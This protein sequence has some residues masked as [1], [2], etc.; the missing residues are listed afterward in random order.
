[1]DPNMELRKLP[2]SVLF[3]LAKMLDAGDNW[4]RLMAIVPR[5]LDVGQPYVPKYKVE[6]IKLIEHAAAK[7]HRS[8]TEIFLDEWGTSGKRR[9]NLQILMEQLVA[10]HLFRAVDYVATSLLQVPPPERPTSGP[11]ARVDVS[12][13]VLENLLP[14]FMN[15]GQEVPG[16]F[17][18]PLGVGDDSSRGNDR[19]LTRL[20]ETLPEEHIAMSRVP[21]NPS[22]R[23]DTRLPHYQFCDLERFT[24]N[25]CER[26]I[27]ESHGR[28]L[29][30]GAFGTVYLGV[31]P[32]RE[33]VAV[34]RLNRD[35]V[36]VVRQ[37]R[38][39]VEALS[40]YQH[41]NLLPL[42]GYSSDGPSYCLVYQYMSNGSLQERL[43]SQA[44]TLL[45][46]AS[47]AW[48]ANT[49]VLSSTA[50]DGEIE[51]PNVILPWQLRLRIALGTARGI[52]HLHIAYEKP[53]IHRDIKSANIL[54]DQDLQPKLGDFGLV[55]LGSSGQQSQSVAMTTTVFGT[56]AYMAPEAFRGDV[57]V[58]LDTFSFGVVLLELLTGLPPYDEGREGC[59]LVT[60]VEEI[61][62][63][64]IVPLL[65]VRAGDWSRTIYTPEGKQP[66]GETPPVLAESVYVV[67][68]ECLEEKRRRPTMM[69]VVQ[70]VNTIVTN[71]TS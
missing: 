4:K 67:A 52:L 19:L 69:V 13:E 34:K 12:D 54:L 57:S 22:L 21:E 65:D 62:D 17:D 58:K 66:L 35:A 31:F 16:T 7:Q 11:A 40:R 59:D 70:R 36:N 8:C 42:L 41:D 15:L 63:D 29:G 50:E 55:R 23:L 26:P 44:L 10:A 56:S 32:S 5:S 33:H 51:D 60:H 49:L 9:P 1:M 53:L 46:S 14:V 37:F 45:L 6:D 24:D 2:M 20:Q 30:T 64:S 61:C 3:N 25:F 27:S 71:L 43:A 28:M 48:L 18:P 38:N 47:V 68:Q 39:E